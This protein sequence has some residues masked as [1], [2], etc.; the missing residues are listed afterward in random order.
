MADDVSAVYIKIISAFVD[1]VHQNNGTHMIIGI[2]DYGYWQHHWLILENFPSQRY[3]LPTG[4][5]KRCFL[6]QLA[7]LATGFIGQKCNAE[8]VIVFPIIIL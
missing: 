3:H 1:I 6:D 7:A 5:V 8:R 4:V 2:Q